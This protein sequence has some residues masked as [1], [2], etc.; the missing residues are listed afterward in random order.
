VVQAF[1]G[2]YTQR[3]DKKG[4]MSIPADF[5]RVL[6]SGDPEAE[7]RGNPRLKIVYGQHLKNCVQAYTINEYQRVIDDIYAMPRERSADQKR[8][9]HL[10]VTQ[11]I[12]LDVDKDGRVILPKSIRDKLSIEEGDIYFRGLVGTFEMWNNDIF[13]STVNADI[14][15][16]LDGMDD[17]F[18]PLSLLGGS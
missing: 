16:W 11:S 7:A 10:Y 4:R 14:D 15:D 1:E 2:E 18:D 5:R 9:A 17:D 6:L 13:Q 12:T 3:V 8:L